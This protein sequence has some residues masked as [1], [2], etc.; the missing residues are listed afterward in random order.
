MPSYLTFAL[1]LP[2]CGFLALTLVTA[3]NAFVQMAVDPSMRGRVMALYMTVFM[4]GTPFGAPLLGW[5]ADH[6]G[7]RWTLIGG[8][9]LTVIGIV[10]AVAMSARRQGLVITR[11]IRS[12]WSPADNEMGPVV[13]D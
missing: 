11:Y 8:G 5:L 3:A 7:A 4:G 12:A 6:A 10:V 2:L 9:A 13:T 1:I